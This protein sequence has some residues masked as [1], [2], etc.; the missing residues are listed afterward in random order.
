MAGGKVE[1]SAIFAIGAKMQASFGSTFGKAAARIQSLG[2]AA[3]KFAKFMGGVALA[4]GAAGAAL[5]AFGAVN[6]FGKIFSGAEAAAK[7][8][9]DRVQQLTAVLGSHPELQ[10]RGEAAIKGQVVAIQSLAAELGKVGVIHS[11]HYESAAKTLAL[12]GTSPKVIG[13]ML[14]V[15]GDVLVATKGVRATQQDMEKLATGLNKAIGSGQVKALQEVGIFMDKNQKKTF[16]SLNR[17]QRRV[18]LLDQLAQKYQGVNEA[19]AST[20]LGK[21]QRMDNMIAAMSESIGLKMIPA[22]AKMAEFWQSVMPA[23]MPIVE[24]GIQ[25]IT[26]AVSGLADF[27]TTTL[28][29]AFESFHKVMISPEMMTAIKSLQTA[30][31]DLVTAVGPPVMALFEALGVKGGNFGEVI[32]KVIVREIEGLTNSIRMFIKIG[33]NLSNLWGEISGAAVGAW[34]AIS[35]AWS[36]AG[37][38]F[39]STWNSISAGAGAAWSAIQSGATT[40]ASNLQSNW[41]HVKT[42]A[43][44]AWASI[45]SSV[46]TAGTAI[47]TTFSS[48]YSTIQSGWQT[49]MSMFAGIPAQISSALAGVTEAIKAPF[50][51]AI[52]VIQDAWSKLIGSITSAAMEIGKTA[53]NLASKATFG[54]IKPAQNAAGGIITKPTLSWVGEKGPEAI[55]P[56]SGDRNR[57]EGLMGAAASA[58]GMGGRGGGEVMNFSPNITING[59]ADSNVIASLDERLRALSRDF[60]SDWQR[61]HAQER[62]TAF[63]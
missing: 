55:V 52:Q 45:S 4:I 51:A 6:I 25:G 7:D 19:A 11:D 9:L 60:M 58:L 30:F 17:E 10:K 31:N 57:S 40:A 59:G 21:I 54:L 61:A 35:G 5:G 26:A 14:P 3:L 42:G 53:Q 48:A 27:A 50:M 28:V 1:Y 24:T 33:Q 18:Y 2:A 16:E 49:V 22:Q 37:G 41:E 43:S 20:D 36:G 8:A 63:G 44:S 47:T 32:G 15:L 39:S 23:L 56:L 13:D 38:F 12:L 29:P 34:S 46:S 62:R